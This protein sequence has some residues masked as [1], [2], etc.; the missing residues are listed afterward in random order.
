M[1]SEFVTVEDRTREG[2]HYKSCEC[3]S[4]ATNHTKVVSCGWRL[5]GM[6]FQKNPLKGGGVQLTK[7]LLLK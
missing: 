7:Y 4:I 1:N 5:L 6:E 2:S 3:F